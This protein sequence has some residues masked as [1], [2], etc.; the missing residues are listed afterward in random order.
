MRKQLDK[1]YDAIS[2][3]GIELSCGGEPRK[4][5]ADRQPAASSSQDPTTWAATISKLHT[6]Q[7]L[8]LP[9]SLREG[10]EGFLSDKPREKAISAA[11]PLEDQTPRSIFDIEEAVPRVRLADLVTPHVVS[12]DGDKSSIWL[13]GS[14]EEETIVLNSG[15]KR[16]VEFRLDS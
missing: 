14:R 13:N 12:V 6:S 9:A 1:V 3:T 5:Q 7:V 4:Q 15:V 2:Q 8:N 11:P 10:D 16:V